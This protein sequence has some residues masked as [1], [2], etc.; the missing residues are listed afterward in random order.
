M[1]AKM[2]SVVD[3]AADNIERRTGNQMKLNDF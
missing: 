3:S 1:L 2:V